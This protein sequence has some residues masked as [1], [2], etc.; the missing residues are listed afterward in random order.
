M[1]E[2]TVLQ[3]WWPFWAVDITQLFIDF[4]VEH[5]FGCR[6]TEPGFV[7][8]IGALEI[9]LIDWLINTFSL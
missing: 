5:R 4:A 7:R 3:S 8:D 2:A 1:P 9:W 6:A